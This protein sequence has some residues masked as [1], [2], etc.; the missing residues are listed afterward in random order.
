MT[1]TAAPAAAEFY[2]LYRLKV[3]SGQS[4]LAPGLAAL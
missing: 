4:F 2:E 1:G 3:G